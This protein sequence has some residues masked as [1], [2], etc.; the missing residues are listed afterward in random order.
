MNETLLNKARLNVVSLNKALINGAVE[1]HGSSAGG[2][3]APSKYIRF[4]DP[5]VEAVLMANGV[6]SDGVGITK[7]DAEAVTTIGTWFKGNTEITSF[8]EFK[9]FI[10]VTTLDNNAFAGCSSLKSIYLRHVVKINGFAFA[11]CTELAIEVDTPSLE[12][13]DYKAFTSSGITGVKNLGHISSFPDAY[14]YSED[15][16]FAFCKNLKYANLPESFTAIPYAAFANCSS[17]ETVTVGGNIA[18]VRNSAFL[19]CESLNEFDFTNV[20][21]IANAAFK[22]CGISEVYAPKVES[23][24]ENA[25][26]NAKLASVYTPLLTQIKKATFK[27]CSNLA[28]VSAESVEIL[29]NDAFFE[30]G[31]EEVYF[32]N[33]KTIGTNAFRL[34]TSLSTIRSL[35]SISSTQ[36]ASGAYGVFY[37]C[38]SLKSAVLPESY[39]S[40]G[41]N[42]FK[43]CSALESIN[44]PS[45]VVKLG[46]SALEGCSSLAFDE[47]N[48]HELT[49]YGSY[50]LYK[51]KAKKLNLGKVP[52]LP[53]ATNVSAHYGDKSVLEKIDIPATC[54]SIPAYSFYNYGRLEEII[55]RAITP[56]ELVNTNALQN[57]NNCP[58]YVPD[59]ALE[60]YKTATNWSA[61][62]DR[63]H[64][65]SELEGSPYIRFADAEVERVLMENN[66]SSDGVGITMA[67][68]QAVT[69]IGTWFKGNRA[70]TSFEEFVY[71]NGV[72]ELV[73]DAF[74]D[75]SLASISLPNS[76]K[77]LNAGVFGRCY[78]LE[79]DFI[80]PQVKALNRAV[81]L[82]TA[83]NSV[84]APNV[85]TMTGANS[86]GVFRLCVALTRVTLGKVANIPRECFAECSKLSEVEIEW[87]NVTEIAQD[88][89]IR[90]TSLPSLDIGG[91]VT[92]IGGGAFYGCSS[93]QLLICRATTPPS[94]ANANAFTDT[95]NC[96]IY[97]PD[98]SVDAYKAAAIWSTYADRIK[99]LSEY[100]ES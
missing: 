39:T 73:I 96:P 83:I 29:G 68:A 46:A 77:T 54:T 49:S 86:E 93:L 31:I 45:G 42:T 9:Y 27:G 15:G 11:K 91:N 52:S 69:S 2:G 20:V 1:R 95:N 24:G 3:G 6:S 28:D 63:I 76:L 23:I 59:A 30:S 58:I 61:Y 100:V 18:E 84:Y 56:P 97:V 67:D 7:E 8:D 79:G 12:L 94:L 75:S 43:N 35:G 80:I 55:V 47:L 33:M 82:A 74:L 36:D 17:L 85:V 34:C 48:L 64:P 78:N 57:T 90:C 38:S 16:M 89:F 87:D 62:A 60:V 81:F 88:A 26:E 98:A 37:G 51:V 65:L 41:Q 66:V 19:N 13:L 14:M 40:I 70:I 5:A 99:P 71:F 32:P 72:T 4:A 21:S 92:S 50:A 25:F 22:N 44:I 10:N 53:S